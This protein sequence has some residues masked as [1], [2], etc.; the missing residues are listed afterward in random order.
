MGWETCGGA[1]CLFAK[2][3]RGGLN[4]LYAEPTFMF[5]I[6]V[7]MLEVLGWSL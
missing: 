3:W 2:K 6:W 5:G 7:R 1:Y 4:L